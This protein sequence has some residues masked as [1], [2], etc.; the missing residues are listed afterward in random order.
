MIQIALTELLV[1]PLKVSPLVVAMLLAACGQVTAPEPPLANVQINTSTQV[2]T[3]TG[4]STE[5]LETE[6]T[7]TSSVPVIIPGDSNFHASDP[8]NVAFAQGR[9]Q[10]VEFFAYWCSVCKAMAPTVHG[11]EGLYEAQ[12]EFIYLDRD[13]PATQ[14]LQDV[15]GYIYQPHFFLLDE[16]GKVLGE[17]RG[18][19]E[20]ELL[21]TAL[22][23]A[24]E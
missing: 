14:R 23:E 20:G 13:D 22:V 24:I 3:E 12:V 8:A 4:L 2:S 9:V 21:Q 19:V 1:K 17:W 7:E 11:L 5:P 6:Q 16:N 18:Y 15:L 10:F